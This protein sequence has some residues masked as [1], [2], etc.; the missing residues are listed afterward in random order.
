[1]WTRTVRGIS[2]SALF[3]NVGGRASVP[4]MPGVDRIKYLT[5]SSMMDVDVLPA[6]LVVIGGSYV[7]LE[8]AQMYR[9]FGSEVTVIEMLPRL[10]PIE[11]ED[12]AKELAKQFGK[13]GIALQLGKTCTKVEDSGSELTVHFGEGEYAETEEAIR[14]LLG[15]EDVATAA[16]GIEPGYSMPR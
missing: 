3:I 12:A 8:F 2:R 1:M 5:N 15:D 14:T 11:D 16:D 7:G 10:I 4:E 13:R 9:R 6:H